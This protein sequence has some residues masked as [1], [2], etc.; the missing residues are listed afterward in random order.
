MENLETGLS[1]SFE[2][3]G[4]TVP[5]QTGPILPADDQELI[6]AIREA[7]EQ[8]LDFGLPAGHSVDAALAELLSWLTDKGLSPPDLSDIVGGTEVTISG[9]TISSSGKFNIVLRVQFQE[10][11]IPDTLPFGGLVDVTEL[12]L[13]LAYDPDSDGSA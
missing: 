7:F 10:D 8:S 6:D 9:L 3:G 11:I 2:I 4:Q 1:V 5:M 13:R 12:G